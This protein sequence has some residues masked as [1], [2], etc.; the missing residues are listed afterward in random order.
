MI[1]LLIKYDKNKVEYWNFV[2]IRFRECFQSRCLSR[3]SVIWKIVINNTLEYFDTIRLF[4]KLYGYFI[5]TYMYLKFN[6]LR[7]S[8]KVLLWKC[9]KRSLK[10]VNINC[11]FSIKNIKNHETRQAIIEFFQCY[12]W[13][14]HINFEF[15]SYEK[16]EKSI[17]F[18]HLQK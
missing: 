8:L 1:K 6:H 12:T 3:F 17:I 11:D 14:K 4:I 16:L 18:C 5:L 13:K 7:I 2:H 9:T 15:L 10:Q